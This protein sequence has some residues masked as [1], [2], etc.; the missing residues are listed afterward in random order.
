MKS[1]CLALIFSS[2]CAFGQT[3]QM[4]TPRYAGPG[5]PAGT[6]SFALTEDGQSISILFDKFIGQITPGMRGLSMSCQIVVPVSLTPGYSLDTTVIYYNGFT[7]LPKDAALRLTTSGF[8]ISRMAPRLATTSLINGPNMNNFSIQ[9][10]VLNGL[11]NIPKCPKDPNLSLTITAEL[12]GRGIQGSFAIDS[13][14]VGGAG[15]V[16]SV[17]L[18]PCRI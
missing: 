7:N 3:Y 10:R 6:A 9:Q 14:D 12:I 13:A 2:L 1:V 11:P 15:V 8:S 16:V 18:K 17:G 5:C 4:G